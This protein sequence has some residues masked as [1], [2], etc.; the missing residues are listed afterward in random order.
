MEI[1]LSLTFAF[2][3]KNSQDPEHKIVCMIH[4]DSLIVTGCLTGELVLWNLIN[5]SYSPC[6]ICS[7][8]KNSKCHSLSFVTGPIP[9]IV[10]S[11]ILVASLHADQK[12]RLW[13]IQDG[14]C[15]SSSSSTLLPNFEFTHILSFGNQFLALYGECSDIIIVD[16]WSM[17]RVSFFSMS[18]KVVKVVQG[19]DE[20]W[21]V[22]SNESLRVFDI[23]AV[24]PYYF[25][26]KS[27]PS[28]SNT[29]KI[30]YNVRED[31]QN[32]EIIANQNIIAVQVQGG[33]RVFLRQWIEDDLKEY[34]HIDKK[35]IVSI[36]C[37]DDLVIITNDSIF[38]IDSKIIE[39]NTQYRKGNVLSRSNSLTNI[40]VHSLHQFVKEQK[41]ELNSVSLT[42]FSQVFKC[43]FKENAIFVYN[44]SDLGVKKFVFTF[45]PIGFSFFADMNLHYIL[46]TGET[47]T[48]SLAYLT[49]E[50]P[51]YIIGT[52]QGK[53]YLS[54]FQPFQTT[55]QFNFHS[56]PIT[57][58]YVKGEKLI[59]C[60]KSHFM[61]IWDLNLS[62]ND[63]KTTPEEN[64][65]R[66]RSKRWSLPCLSNQSTGSKE[67]Q[68]NKPVQTIEFFFGSIRKIL[69]VDGIRENS[70]LESTD[71]IV[72]QSKD[73]SVILV[74]LSLGSLLGLFPPVSGEIQEAYFF[75]SLGYIYLIS[76]NNDLFVFNV[77][78][79]VQERVVSGSDVMTI[80]RR[81]ARSR[82]RTETFEEVVEET[83][84]KQKVTMYNLRQ[85][86]PAISQSALKIS[87]HCLGNLQVSVLSINIQMILKKL[88]KLNGPSRQLEYILSLFTCW[89]PGCKAHESCLESVKEVLSLN[90]PA[91]RGN[92]GVIGV[93][94]TV[95]FTLPGVESFFQVS[96]Y[97]TA[98][99][100][101]AGYA[102]IEGIYQLMP[103]ATKTQLRIVTGHL[104][105]SCH[106][107]NDFQLPFF[108][109]LAIQSLYGIFTSRFILQ[110]NLVYLTRKSKQ[111]FL[112]TL[113][114]IL[115]DNS[116][117]SNPNHTSLIQALTTILLSYFLIELKVQKSNLTGVLLSTLKKM[118]KSEHEGYYIT[119]ASILGKG[120]EH[121]KN[122]LNSDQIKEIVEDLVLY[123]CKDSQ[124]HKQVF[125]KALISI[126]SCDF[127]DFIEI[128]AKEIENMDIDPLYPSS[129]I[130]VLDLFIEQKYDEMAAYL[131]A[132][133]EL[134][135]RTLNPHNPMLRKM[136]IEKAGHTLKTLLMKL[137]MIT[138]SQKMQ[139]LA[140]GTMDN[141]VVVYD[142]KT[143]SQW[144]I[145][146]GHN[147]PVCAVEFN[148]SGDFLASFSSVDCTVRIWKL[149][150]GFFQDLIGNSTCKAIQVVE[151]ECL[152][153]R[154]LSYKKFL[155]VVRLSWTGDD[156][157]FLTREDG[158]RVLIKE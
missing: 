91:I 66:S 73:F 107:S 8:G 38:T 87:G 97:V 1:P 36:F 17:E 33:L 77:D 118:L 49:A 105:S 27:L 121:W 43:G 14:R 115:L 9:E 30:I 100:M 127:I 132:V 10:G 145:L 151:V 125:Y 6:I 95:S 59:S 31:I 122:E 111:D 50:W 96:P 44:P 11:K 47:I 110:D 131:P 69:R 129:C 143:A 55:H 21:A 12:I 152:D 67:I 102:L 62:Y 137:P 83:S 42:E 108:P 147:G 19:A 22:D 76:D 142:L 16:A 71:L 28:F 146:K 29:A 81:P 57:C 149:K 104:S 94:N 113:S 63:Q 80:I 53:I 119:A 88:K 23:P 51:I 92:I 41:F 18:G 60:C 114:E 74:S 78:S 37:E 106:Q 2:W 144:K 93:D 138:F 86:F 3:N 40:K 20:L 75:S 134:I 101:S 79:N 155:D 154:D 139:R 39:K 34:F 89:Q 112:N 157:I 117:P 135:V 35:G 24:F 123:G 120:M 84:A 46:A 61:C 56:S 65:L 130:R 13:D 64:S 26:S 156:K 109:I 150:S 148:K 136:T 98:L 32:L 116:S 68:T 52:S 158:T 99:V 153:T 70:P 48:C 54:H 5:T 58:I 90:L 128:L 85:F 72:G 4:K 126:A 141:L 140:I 82:I 7:P 133:I 124:Q 15:T 103:N 45:K 25:S